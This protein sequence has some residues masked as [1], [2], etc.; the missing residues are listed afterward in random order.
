MGKKGY[1]AYVL[2]ALIVSIEDNHRRLNFP[3]KDF[4]TNNN[5]VTVTR[6]TRSLKTRLKYKSIAFLKYY[7]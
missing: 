3:K 2:V 7:N 5:N 4:H 1:M 6:V